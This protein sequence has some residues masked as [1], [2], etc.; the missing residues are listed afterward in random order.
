MPPIRKRF[1]QHFLTDRSALA[2]IAAALAPTADDFVV[3]I[4]PGRGALTDLLV[5]R[6]RRF[7]AIEV[8][9]DLARALGERYSSRQ[10]VHVECADV[11]KTPLGDLAGGPFLLVGN[12]PYNITTPIIFHALTPPLPR[13]S[14]FLIQ[15]EVAERLVAEPGSDAYGALSVNVQGVCD[16]ELIGR[17]G[18]GA[19]HPPPKVES[20]IVRLTQKANPVWGAS[21]SEH[22]R[23]FV[24]ACFGQRRKQLG[25]VL[26]SVAKLTPQHVT[27]ILAELSIDATAR[28]ETLGPAQFA[29]LLD[30]C[31]RAGLAQSS[32]R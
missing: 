10:H 29:Q 28:P 24:V 11:L 8:D 14:V 7:V 12:V 4:G 6:C 9:R 5:E 16:V 3:E 2:R 25:R 21:E 22:I 19:F 30:S 18:A 26:R 1:G 27:Q 23:R 15:R 17:V 13:R 32:E 31:R 20:A